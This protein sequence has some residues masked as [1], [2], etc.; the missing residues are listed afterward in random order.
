[1]GFG[2]MGLQPVVSRLGA[3]NFQLE[4]DDFQWERTKGLEDFKQLLPTGLAP[5][6]G[7]LYVNLS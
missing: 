1:M 6:G 7:F 4:T 3:G 2:C 5:R